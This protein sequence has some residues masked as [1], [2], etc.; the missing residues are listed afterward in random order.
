MTRNDDLMGRVA[1]GDGEAFAELVTPHRAELLRF[2]VRILGGD[3]QA[4][5]EVVQESMLN[6]YRALEQGARPQSVRPWLF[7]IVRNCALNTRR[8]S[9]AT[10]A[11]ADEDGKMLDGALATVASL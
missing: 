9:Q 11:L 4:G 10:C 5:E 2:A 8:R 1:A 7:A 6:A 3:G